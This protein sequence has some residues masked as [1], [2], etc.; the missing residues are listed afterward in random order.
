MRFL[1]MALLAASTLQAQQPAAFTDPDRADKVRATAPAVEQMFRDYAEERHMPG[2][3][4]G[5]VL[6]GEL[7]YSG[8]FGLANLETHIPADTTSLFRI[9]SMSKSFTAL[10]I[11]QLRDAGKLRLDDPV[12]HVVIREHPWRRLKTS[13]RVSR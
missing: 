7:V 9:A 5:V 10:A 1:I 2:F 13:E 6:D 12:P 11:L 4:Y 8:A 3:A